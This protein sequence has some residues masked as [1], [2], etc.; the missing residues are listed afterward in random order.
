[1]KPSIDQ[2][3]F[4]AYLWTQLFSAKRGLNGHRNTSTESLVADDSFAL[5]FQRHLNLSFHA[6]K[7]NYVRFISSCSMQRRNQDAG[8]GTMDIMPYC[9]EGDASVPQAFYW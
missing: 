6:T 1:M 8:F 9:I 5:L 4:S 7:F 2:P 3:Y